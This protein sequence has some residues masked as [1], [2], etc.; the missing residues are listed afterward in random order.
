MHQDRV[1]PNASHAFI[2]ETPGP[3]SVSFFVLW[4]GER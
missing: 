2:R 4:A 3:F 1:G